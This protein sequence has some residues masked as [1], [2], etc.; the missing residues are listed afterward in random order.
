MNIA[1]SQTARMG[2]LATVLGRDALVLMR[3]SGTERLN[4]LFDWQV[5]CLAATAD[6]D[7]DGL[8]GTHATV[9]LENH[10]GARRFD[11]IVTEAR[12]LGAGENGHRYRLRLQPWLWLASLR[13][14]QRIF[15]TK[16]V[17][18][19]VEEL[20]SAY[21]DA[22]KLQVATTSDYP[23]LEYTVQFR[24]SDMDFACRLLE[25][26]GISYHF[27][28]D[29]G[30]HTMVLT[31][32]ASAHPSIGARDF[33]P[34]EGHH[35][36]DEEHFWDWR[37]ARRITTGAIRLT[38]YNFK[39]PNAA[40][41]VDRQGDAAHAQ[42]RIESFDWPGDYLDQ[43]RGRM[44]AQLRANA[45]RG[46]D[47]RFEA[48]GDVLSL[49]AGSRVTLTGDAVP[50]HGAGY[51]CLAATHSY[52][53]DNYGSGGALGDELAY[54]GHYVLMP[55]TAPMLPERKTPL[56]DVRGPQTAVVVG[57]GEIDCDEYG[58]ILV[59][60]HWDLDGAYSMRCRV[61]QN[62]AGNGWG[63]MVIPRIG[64]EV[65]VEFLDGDPDQPMVTGCVYNGRNAVPY[66]L[67]KHKTRSTFKTKTHKGGGFN[68]LR[69]EDEKG[70]EEIFVHA[71]KD[72]NE[73]TLNNH[74]ERID[75]NWLQ[76]VGRHK[77][78]EVDGSHSESVHGSMMLHVGKSGKGRVLDAVSRTIT[79]GIGRLA[80]TLPVPGL[81]D[82]GSGIYSLF[83]DAVITETTPG[84]K[85]QFIGVTKSVTV[86][87]TLVE[88]AG[89][90]IQ[91]T[92]GSQMSLE[93]G[94]SVTIVSGSEIEVKVGKAEF[95]MTS[96]GFIRL[97]GDTLLLEFE[98]GVELVGGKEITASAPKIKL[99]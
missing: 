25:R 46:Q 3:F 34:D 71:Q 70:Q 53:S 10:T 89:N 18:Q 14:N 98:N 40:M 99:N 77:V 57:E 56:A 69:F 75:N 80:V 55:E 4:G 45:E 8:I 81:H 47:R 24:E 22:G 41:E 15:H 72:R 76:S 27:L 42:G 16:T 60:F 32:M 17:I 12:W 79:E 5:D 49:T 65:L 11:G 31:D 87:S 84:A 90:S 9:T 21:A 36:A 28:H 51:L 93:A 68:E 78:I 82:G 64:M 86:G 73:K 20:L 61:S 91:L 33:H 43:G 94:N 2:S 23:E 50:G 48:V 44:V 66:E 1:F 63:G 52:T 97:S 62:W 35:Q 95:R 74:S 67:P 38:D 37:P 29:D 13:R 6:V 92:S 39:T 30:A 96:D 19:I 26:H 88:Q 59:R 83:A 85:S 58:R 7:F 54:R